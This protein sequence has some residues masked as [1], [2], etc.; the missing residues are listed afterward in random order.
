ML[1][2]ILFSIFIFLI[3][4]PASIIISYSTYLFLNSTLN[5]S[6]ITVISAVFFILALG[7]LFAL[8]YLMNIIMNKF[9]EKIC[10][11]ESKKKFM[12]V[13]VAIPVVLLCFLAIFLN[14]DM[15]YNNNGKVVGNNDLLMLSSSLS[16]ISIVMILFALAYVVVF[17]MYEISQKIYSR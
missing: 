2:K 11:I 14:Y 1:K 10:K 7:I 16:A 4:I 3:Y 15:L 12:F 6:N 9:S 17:V 13:S 8:I 5:L